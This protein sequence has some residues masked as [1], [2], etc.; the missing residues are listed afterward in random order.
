MG[1]LCTLVNLITDLQILCCE[2]HK[3]RLAAGLRPDQLRGATALPQ[4]V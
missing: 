1:V 3:M 4:T 2:L